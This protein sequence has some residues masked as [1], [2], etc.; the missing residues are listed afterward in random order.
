MVHDDD[1]F[2]G[3][4]ES[5]DKCVEILNDM[6]MYNNEIE[7]NLN[8]C[9]KGD[10]E[11]FFNWDDNPTPNTICFSEVLGY[12]CCSDPDTVVYTTDENDK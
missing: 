12:L 6:D 9:T 5:S 4:I 11:K 2:F 10:A 7:L 8:T 3:M 1:G